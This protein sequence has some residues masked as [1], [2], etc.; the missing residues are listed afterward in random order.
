[1]KLFQ[2]VTT[3]R[4]D[5]GHQRGPRER[6]Q[7]APEE[8]ERRAAVDRGGILELDRELRMNGRRMMIV[9]G[10]PERRLGKRDAEQRLVEV[11][12]SQQEV[13]RQSTATAIGK[14]R[15]NVKNV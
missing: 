1:M 10:M 4:I 15:P 2:L 9:I 12:L 13:E 6:Q 5:H 3:E 7:N 14:R 8:A 11:E